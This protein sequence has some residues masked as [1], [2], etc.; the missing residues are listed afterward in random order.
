LYQ[1]TRSHK[2]VSALGALCS[3]PMERKVRFY[4]RLY[5]NCNINSVSVL[6][7]LRQLRKSIRGRYF[8]IW[9]RFKIHRSA[10]ILKYLRG[11]LDI[12]SFS[13]PPY[14]PELNP[15]EYVWSHLKVNSLSNFVPLDESELKT[16]AKDSICGIRNHYK[17][18]KSLLHH[19]P[20]YFFR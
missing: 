6:N 16:G 20:L 11:Q 5:V 12:E 10:K 14:A 13:L 4:F 7:F 19:S 2:K 1:R 17:L 15:V 8:V 9:D 18:L 3:S